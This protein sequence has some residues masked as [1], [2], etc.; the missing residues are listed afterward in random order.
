LRDEGYRED[1]PFNGLDSLGDDGLDGPDDN[2][3]DDDGL[4]RG[5]S[6]PAPAAN[7]HLLVSAGTA[8]GWS[9]EPGELSRFGPL[10]APSTRDLIRKAARNPATRW[11]VTLVDESG[12]AVAHACARGQHPWPNPREGGQAAGAG[13]PG[14][15]EQQAQ[16]AALLDRLGITRFEPIA[17]GTCDHRHREDRYTPSRQLGD[18]IR[19]RT[20][21]CPAPHCGASAI[22]ADLDHTIPWPGGPGTCECNLGPPC[23]HHH[24]VKQAPGWRL[25][26]SDPGIMRWSTPSGRLY[27]T[28]PTL[29]H[30]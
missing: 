25:D 4:D 26:Q 11:H 28:R 2:G 1:E 21:T 20:A 14:R 16:V 29:Y 6:P 7:I 19:A 22:R 8:L 13:P 3:P 17:K 9:N 23:R 10:D 18:L 24:R 30:L 15:A 5:E 27:E 12:E